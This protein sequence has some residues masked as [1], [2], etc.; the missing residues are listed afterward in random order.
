VTVWMAGFRIGPVDTR[1]PYSA[2]GGSRTVTLAGGPDARQAG[3][4]RTLGRFGRLWISRRPIL[5]FDGDVP[6]RDG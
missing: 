4:P 2:A 6:V 1:L 5:E 3:Y